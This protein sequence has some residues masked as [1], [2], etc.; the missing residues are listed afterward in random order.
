MKKE[1]KLAIATAK[2]T[3][4]ECLYKELLANGWDKKLYGLVKARKR[5][6]WD[7]DQVK[8]IKDEEDK[9]LVEDAHNRQKWQA[10]FHK[11]L[12]EEVDMNIMLGDSD[13]S[14]IIWVL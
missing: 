13:R 1:A 12:N 2:M 6:S 7:L 5:R 3:D 10:Y 14:L 9:V 8:C 11:L 4:F